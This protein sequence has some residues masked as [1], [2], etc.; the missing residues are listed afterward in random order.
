M[1]SNSAIGPGTLSLGTATLNTGG[2]ARTLAN[3]LTLA[4]NP[5]FSGAEAL[6]FSGAVNMTGSRTLTVSGTGVVTFDGLISGGARKLTKTGAGTLVL[7]NANTYTLGTALSAG[8]LV[9]GNDAAAGTG[10]LTLTTGTLQ[11]GGGART[12]GNLVSLGG[13]TTYS[14]ANDFTFTNA[15]TMTK[16]VTLTVNNSVAF[17]GVVGGAFALTKSGTGTLSLGGT[18]ANTYSGSSI[19]NDGTLLLA[20]TAG[21][22]AFASTTLTIGDSLGAAGSAIVQWNA[23]D[24][25]P[26]AATVNLKLDGVLN[27][28][29][30]TERIGALTTTGGSIIGSGRLDL[31]GNVTATALTTAVTTV[32]ANLGLNGTRTF[33]INNN[34]VTGDNDFIVNGVISDGTASS[35]LV[36]TGLGTLYLG[37]ANTYTGTTDLLNGPLVVDGALGSAAVNLGDTITTSNAASLLFGTATGRTIANTINVRAGSTGLLTLGGQNTTGINIFSGPINLSHLLTVTAA[38]GGGVDFAGIISGAFGLTKIGGGTVRLSNANTFS[39]LTTVSAGTLAYGVSDALGS[40]GVTI[41]G[42]TLDLGADHSDTVGTVTLTSG[43][44]TGSGS[45]TLTSNA[46]YAVSSGAIGVILGGP[47]GLT[48]TTAGVVTLAGANSYTGATTVSAG[49]LRLGRGQ[50]HLGRFRGHAFDR[51]DFRPER[52]RRSHR[53]ARGSRRQRHARERNLERGSE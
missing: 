38:T 49:T 24:Q 4:G 19:V 27:L 11:A 48:K 23:A 16:A 51:G 39:G 31:G 7:N 53:L 35:G 20:K 15:V 13:N 10:T 50:F 34:A 1:G 32:S 28:Q 40:G 47:V 36:K 18:A 25:V 41:N 45:S 17:G 37:G 43:S 22:N 21:V 5:T 30:F 9:L 44:I 42:G 26:D 6:G 33:L 2:A 29:S 12:I 52:L 46:N 14:G 8:T 3:A